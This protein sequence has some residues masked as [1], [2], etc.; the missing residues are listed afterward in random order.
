MF[1]SYSLSAW[2]GLSRLGVLLIIQFWLYKPLEDDKQPEPPRLSFWRLMAMKS[3]EWKWMAAGTLCS[4]VIGFSMPLFIVVF[5][6][7]FG[8]RYF[9]ITIVVVWLRLQALGHPWP[10]YLNKD[11]IK[12]SG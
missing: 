7:L 8:V 2:L 4:V 1:S 12:K 10:K 3:K 9:F 11:S 6:D 5:G